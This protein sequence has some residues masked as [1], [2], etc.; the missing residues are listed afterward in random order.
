VQWNNFGA[1]DPLVQQ[2]YAALMRG[3]YEYL[4]T[5]GQVQARSLGEDVRF[6]VDATRYEKN[7]RWSFLAQPDVTL[8]E[9]KK[10]DDKPSDPIA[11]QEDKANKRHVYAQ[12][13]W[14][15]PGLYKVYLTPIG[16]TKPEVRAFAF[17]VDPAL[18]SD[19]KRA[20][21]DRVEPAMAAPDGKRGRFAFWV[22]GDSIERFKE[23]QPDASELPWLYLFFIIILVV[24]QALAVHLSFHTRS[25]DSA[26]PGAVSSGQAAAA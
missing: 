8:D 14:R 2:L 21:R 16:D 24:E 12:L 23:K 10:E 15:R 13:N 1:G 25:E 6:S 5:E 19:L 9:V 7:V 26:A 18:E 3:L 11:M 20:E 4:V 22:P 17:N